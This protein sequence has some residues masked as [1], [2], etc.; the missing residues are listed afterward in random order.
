MHTRANAKGF[1]GLETWKSKVDV[2]I[3]AALEDARKSADGAKA[4]SNAAGPSTESQR[5]GTGWR[6]PASTQA[7][8]ARSSRAWVPWAFLGLIALAVMATL[9]NRERTGSMV[10][11]SPSTADVPASLFPEDLPPVGSDHL[12]SAS[13]VNY[14]IAE[15]FRLEGMR[16]AARSN[17]QIDRFNVAVDNY[18]ARCGS[19]RYYGDTVNAAR[20]A[21]APHAATL[22]LAG[23]HRLEP[24]TPATV[25]VAPTS[26]NEPSAREL[27][28]FTVVD[29][30]NVRARPSTSS[31]VVAKL[32]ALTKVSARQ[33]SGEW[34][35]IRFESDGQWNEGF[36]A[37]RLLQ[38]G[39]ESSVRI[40]YCEPEHPR[41]GAVLTQS[42]RGPHSINV[43]A[44]SKD[45]VVKLKSKAGRTAL[46]FYVRSG[47]SATID[48]V[49]EGQYR[50]MFATGK[51]YSRKCGVF[52][53][54]M[55]VQQDPNFATF[56]TTNDSENVY[57]S[58]A[59][60]RL[61]EQVAGNFRPEQAAISS[62]SD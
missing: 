37:R 56:K 46:A 53:D 60:Y 61:V 12:L 43:R 39:D 15:D 51:R 49:P 1:A 62:F 52:L 59:E 5:A 38:F 23:R 9:G 40:A 27:Q 55:E 44:G 8:V 4:D 30:A 32:P 13:Q 10:L 17:G 21:V 22:R 29:S 20:R 41:S 54:D 11:Q 34:V 14:C 48:S 6:P 57:T 16:D 35:Q 3:A 50:V 18:N 31:A 33:P 7:P 36:V 24:P 19:Y 47:E 28:A 26:P 42:E 2:Y 25:V 58:I 45:V